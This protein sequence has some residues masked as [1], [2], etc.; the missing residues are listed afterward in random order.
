MISL[1]FVVLVYTDHLAESRPA[2]C[3]QTYV[4]PDER[5][6]HEK[7]EELRKNFVDALV[8]FLTPKKDHP[9]G[10]YQECPDLVKK[11]VH[12][13]FP[14]AALST[15]DF[16]IIQSIVDFFRRNPKSSSHQDTDSLDP[17]D[18]IFDIFSDKEVKDMDGWVKQ[19]LEKLV[20]EEIYNEVVATATKGN[21]VNSQ[22]PSIIAG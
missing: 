1:T 14:R 13:F 21:L 6:S 22:L 17:I 2:D 12:F 4:P 15:G 7:Q 10:S 3:F 18:V 5:L 20:P 16:R 9:P 11:F 8:R 19:K